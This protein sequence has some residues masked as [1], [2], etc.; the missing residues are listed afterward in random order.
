MALKL[1]MFL[2]GSAND[3]GFDVQRV[4][5]VTAGKRQVDVVETDKHWQS[6]E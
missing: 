3:V 1:P 5:L 4:E 6:R 2:M